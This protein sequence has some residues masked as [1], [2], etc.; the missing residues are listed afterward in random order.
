MFVLQPY[1]LGPPSLANANHKSQTRS[2]QDY[3]SFSQLNMG[4]L[5]ASMHALWGFLR[6]AGPNAIIHQTIFFLS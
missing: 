5:S 4:F 6:A 1:K 3:K 2:S